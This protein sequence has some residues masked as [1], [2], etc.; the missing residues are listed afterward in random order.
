MA[1]RTTPYSKRE[2][3]RIVEIISA[4]YKSP[5][6]LVGLKASDAE[7]IL[8][9][10]KPEKFANLRALQKRFRLMCPL[11][12]WMIFV[13]TGEDV[14]EEKADIVGLDSQWFDKAFK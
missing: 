13:Q 3:K 1:Q 10:E 7:E 2:A 4:K 11:G 9:P 14:G 8:S 12:R 5:Y 6:F